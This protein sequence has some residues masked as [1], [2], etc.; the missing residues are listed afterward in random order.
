MPY[1]VLKTG[2]PVHF[3]IEEIAHENNLQEIRGAAGP[4]SSKHVFDSN[5]E[6][7]M[8]KLLPAQGGHIASASILVRETLIKLS[9]FHNRSS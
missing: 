6:R 1:L 7:R 3:A 4:A 2:N 5:G 9:T 8:R